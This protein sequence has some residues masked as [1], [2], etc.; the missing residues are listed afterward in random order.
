[1]RLRVRLRVRLSVFYIATQ[2]HL[3]SSAEQVSLSHQFVELLVAAWVAR[4]DSTG[5]QQ[6]SESTGR[7]PT[8]SGAPSPDVAMIGKHIEVTTCPCSTSFAHA[9]CVCSVVVAQR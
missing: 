3:T 7:S 9:M 6:A 2:L 5:I 1:M 4:S 8:S